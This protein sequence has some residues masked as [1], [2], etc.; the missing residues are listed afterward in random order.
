VPRGRSDEPRRPAAPRPSPAAAGFGA[1][2]R[3]ADGPATAE[4]RLFWVILWAI[5][6]AFVIG[7][8]RPNW[9]TLERRRQAK[10]ELI[11]EIESLAEENARLK[12]GIE[13]LERGDIET[14]ESVA[15]QRL[16]WARPGEHLRSR[17]PEGG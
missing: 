4:I 9:E 12:A 11:G 15:R 14:W 13:A 6:V 3:R 10:A 2:A 5:A 1:Q 16:G 17:Q 7:V 8:Y